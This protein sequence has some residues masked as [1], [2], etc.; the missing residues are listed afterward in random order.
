MRPWSFFAETTY[1]SQRSA[2]LSCGQL[3]FGKLVLAV[4]TARQTCAEGVFAFA[5]L[6]KR[7]FSCEDGKQGSI[8][9]PH[10]NFAKMCTRIARE[11]ATPT[12]GKLMR[13][14]HFGHLKIKIIAGVARTAK[15]RGDGASDEKS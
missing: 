15:F 3:A 14:Y 9:F 2:H 13:R 8:F 1:L 7:N 5:F 6:H 12:R 10:F 11:F 4:L